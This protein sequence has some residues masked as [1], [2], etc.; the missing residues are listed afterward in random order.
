MKR[1]SLLRIA[2]LSDIHGNLPALH[3][4]LDDVRRRGA[5]LIVN[6]GDLLSGPL[7]PQQTA[8]LLRALDWPTISGNHE[9]QLLACA[10]APGDA[11]D[12]YAYAR[13]TASDRAWLRTLPSTLRPLGDVLMV[14]GRPH[15]DLEYLLET[16]DARGARQA[17]DDQIDARL[18]TLD[19]LP[20]LLLCRHSHKPRCVQRAGCCVV[21]PGSVG[22][23]AFDDS[24]GGYHVIE[25]ASPH[26]R[27]ALC[28]RSQGRWNVALIAVAYRWEDAA[29][30][31][32]QC[33]F[34]D[35]ARWLRSG[36]A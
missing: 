10:D 22:L 23:P 17:S 14:H 1:D 4:V 8:A 13:I 29:A 32:A 36:R 2:V 34:D 21:N 9:R 35:W 30:Q 25:N 12:L 11:A 20:A 33:G 15:T 16:V 18:A 19:T 28:E 7:W 24:H 27:Y 3:A 31:A 6:C 26:A 5:D